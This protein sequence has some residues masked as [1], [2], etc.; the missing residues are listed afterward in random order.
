MARPPGMA[1]PGAPAP[2]GACAAGG[3]PAGACGAGVAA[4][5][6]AGAAGAGP[7]GAPAGGA[8]RP[9]AVVAVASAGGAPGPPG[10]MPR[11]APAGIA[12]AG[13]TWISASPLKP[14]EVGS[15]SSAGNSSTRTYLSGS[16]TSSSNSIGTRLS[17]RTR[18]VLPVA[19]I[20]FTP[21]SFWAPSA[22]LA[23]ASTS[24][25]FLADSGLAAGACASATAVA[26]IRSRTA[27]AVS[28]WRK[29]RSV[30][31]R[32]IGHRFWPV[33]SS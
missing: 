3:A 22:F 11:P 18:R 30:I 10:G 13:G 20:V 23:A 12:G 7:A 21:A 9:P 27:V 8:G 31:S 17:P 6:P 32:F 33:S 15:V 26:E 14:D 29:R 24:S 4:P 16:S 2:A 28:E 5:G 1:G 25:A 19:T